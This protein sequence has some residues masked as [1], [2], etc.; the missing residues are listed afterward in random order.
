MKVYVGIDVGGTNTDA[1]AICDQKIIAKSKQLTT[2]SITN[3]VKSA[4]GSVLQ[5]LSDNF[6]GRNIL[7]SRVNIG[8]THFL[9]AVLQRKNL[10]T[11][12]VVR[13]CGPASRALP[14]F[15]DFPEDLRT[16]VDGGYYFIDGGYEVSGEEIR[17]ING[18]EVREIVTC[19]QRTGTHISC[20][21]ALRTCTT[22]IRNNSRNNARC[23]LYCLPI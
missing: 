1:V 15:C 7:V 21:S 10:A 3:G 22:I 19:I 16:V 20:M 8:T 13:L 4:L 17:P 14:P 12:A 23:L 9:N 6:K 11:V 2:S 18:D 5:Q